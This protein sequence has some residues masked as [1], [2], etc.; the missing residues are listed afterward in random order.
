[1]YK[2]IFENSV[3][4]YVDWE[5]YCKRRPY[6]GMPLS[7]LRFIESCGRW[8]TIEKMD[9]SQRTDIATYYDLEGDRRRR[10]E[11]ERGGK[12]IGRVE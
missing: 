12:L 7:F 8:L 6:N 4:L 10:E 3:I 2:I 9:G 5:N 1:M 11:R